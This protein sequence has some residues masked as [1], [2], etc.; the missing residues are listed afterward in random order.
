MITQTFCLKAIAEP[1]SREEKSK[2]QSHWVEEPEIT[3]QE[4]KVAVTCLPEYLRK[5]SY[6][7]KEFQKS[8]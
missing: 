6:T 5:E 1:L 2:L 8:E 3:V 4:A 7:E